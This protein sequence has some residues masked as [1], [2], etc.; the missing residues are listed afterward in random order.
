VDERGTIV[1]LT[2]PACRMELYVLSGGYRGIVETI[3]E[4]FDDAVDV[5]RAGSSENNFEQYFTLNALTTGFRGIDRPRLENDFDR[6]QG[7]HFLSPLLLS[8]AGATEVLVYD[9][10]R[11]SSPAQINHTIR[12]LRGRVPGEWP[13][14]EDW[15]DLERIYRIRYLAPGDAR[16]TGLSG[17]YIDFGILNPD[18]WSWAPGS[19]WPGTLLV[20]VEARA[21]PPVPDGLIE[22][23]D[24]VVTTLGRVGSRITTRAGVVDVPPAPARR[25]S[26]PTGAGDAYRAGLVAGLQGGWTTLATDAAHIAVTQLGTDAAGNPLSR[27]TGG[28]RATLGLGA[29]LFSGAVHFGFARPIDHQARWRFVGGLGRSF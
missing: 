9:I 5:Q 20:N 16:N 2:V 18:G 21:A 17:A 15:P 25:E 12:Q 13:E 19:P 4:L 22:L 3:A 28:F 29:T 14:I 24:I 8:N 11:L 23:A 10:Q 6:L 27:A 7:R 26:D 1:W